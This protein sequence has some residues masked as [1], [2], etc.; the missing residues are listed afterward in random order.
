MAVAIIVTFPSS[1]I[2]VPLH[3]SVIP[4]RHH[5]PEYHTYVDIPLRNLPAFADIHKWRL[6]VLTVFSYLTTIPFL[7][8]IIYPDR[9]SHIG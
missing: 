6:L 4:H 3:N 7:T 2:S 5:L 8:G 1:P 9:N